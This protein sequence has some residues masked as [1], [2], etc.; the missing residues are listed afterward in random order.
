M[1]YVVRTVDFKPERLANVEV[2]QRSLPNLEVIIDTKRDGYQSYFAACALL[3]DTGG[4]ILE[5]DA[6]LCSNFKDRIESIIHEKGVHHVFNFFEK[7]KTWFPTGF[8]GGSNFAST[9]CTY[10]PP[11][12]PHKLKDYYEQFRI[13]EP[14]KHTGMATDCLINFVLRME[15]L[16]YWRIRPC[17][18]QHHLFK[19][20][21]NSRPLD[22]Q[23]LFFVDDLDSRGVRY[24]DL[25]PTK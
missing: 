15:K 13:K 16:K 12:F 1:R 8:V 24:E 2:L 17:L 9:V 4:V 6:I 25:Q 23:T 10:L 18:V 22:R 21:I 14:N 11:G 7:P 20:S 5:D 19:S 3:E